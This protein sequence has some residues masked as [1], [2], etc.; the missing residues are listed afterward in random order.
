[1]TT[2]YC[3]AVRRVGSNG[4]APLTVAPAPEAPDGYICVVADGPAAVDQWGPINITFTVDVARALGHALI[5]CANE[6]GAK[7]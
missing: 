3:Y 7:K 4:E 2:A 5:A 1:M 6:V